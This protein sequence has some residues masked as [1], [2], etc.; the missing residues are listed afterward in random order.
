MAV[1]EKQKALEVAILQIESNGKGS[2]MKM[3]KRTP[4]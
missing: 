2:I 1:D 3:G 4:R